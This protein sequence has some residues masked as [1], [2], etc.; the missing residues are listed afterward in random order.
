[1]KPRI[2]RIIT[3]LNVGGPATHVQVANAGLEARGWET[4]LVFGEIDAGEAEAPIRT[5]IPTLRV[6]SLQRRVSPASDARVLASLIRVIRSFRPHVIHTHL[7]KAGLVGRVAAVA[8]S[9]AMR[10]HTFHG[11]VF[12]GYFSPRVARAILG[13]ERALGSQTDA[14]IA[15]SEAQRD[16]LLQRRIARSSH[17]H[18]V[19]LGIDSA[20]FAPSDKAAARADLGL[21]P[22]G[23]V[24]VAV[25]RMVP[26]KRLDRLVR[27]MKSV[28]AAIPQAKLYLVGGGPERPD[29]ERLVGEL[30]LRDNVTF[31]GWSSA[32]ERWYGAADVVALSS[33][34]EGTPLALIEAAAAGRPVVATSVGG[35]PDVVADG[36]TGI[37]VS[38]GDEA[39]MAHALIEVLSNPDMGRRLGDAARDASGRFGADRL[40]GDLDHLYRTLL[41]EG[42]S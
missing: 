5:D 41:R 17:I 11:N 30:G 12:D 19:P 39:A 20:R 21:D 34:R 3:R 13:V 31:V 27:A 10:A 28:A 9:R 18:I 6:S 32:T 16:E 33:A 24:L 22:R 1:M 36:V 23:P 8:S 29:L 2:L 26:I 4:L 15:L 38:D 7:S 35:V 14:V 25:G 42:R 37:V 40:V